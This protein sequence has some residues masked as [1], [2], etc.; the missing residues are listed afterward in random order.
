MASGDAFDRL[1]TGRAVEGV[2]EILW[3]VAIGDRKLVTTIQEGCGAAQHAIGEPGT[4]VALLVVF[5][6]AM[7][8]P[9]DLVFAK[10]EGSVVGRD[11]RVD[12]D[13]HKATRFIASANP[14]QDDSAVLAAIGAGS[15]AGILDP[16]PARLMIWAAL[17]QRPRGGR[18][19]L[20]L[21]RVELEEIQK[22]SRLIAVRDLLGVK[23]A[24]LKPAA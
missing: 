22:Q 14:R 24:F 15:A 7:V 19:I 18:E 3:S 9:A 4:L 11:V 6:H 10:K 8:P 17:A 12:R 1:Q 23:S 16:R 5:E 21:S 2:D 13:H 20:V